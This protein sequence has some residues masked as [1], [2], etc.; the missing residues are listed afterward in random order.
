MHLLESL[1]AEAVAT[2]RADKIFASIYGTDERLARAW[3]AQWLLM[4][5]ASEARLRSICSDGADRGV[6][7]YVV[8]SL[9]GLEVDSEGL[10]K[11]ANFEATGWG[12]C[13]KRLQLHGLPHN[14]GLELDILAAP[15]L[16]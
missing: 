10:V 13:Q 7:P 2:A 3:F 4:Q 11:L 14:D 5:K 9:R 6:M 1:P 16:L 12:T 8:E 15:F